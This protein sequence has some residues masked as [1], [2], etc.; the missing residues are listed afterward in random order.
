[1]CGYLRLLL[2]LIGI[3]L[4]GAAGAIAEEVEF[5][6]LDGK[7]RLPAELRL[8]QSDPPFRAIVF[9]HGCSGLKRNGAI[10][11][12]YSAWGKLLND[13]GFAVLMVDSAAPRGFGTTCGAG[14]ARKRMYFNRPLDAYGA[15]RYL[16][17]RPDVRA[18]GIGLAG[19]SQG[20]GIT[21]LTVVSESIGRPDPRPE[22]D[23]KA[24]VAFYPSACSTRAQSRPYTSVEPGQWSTSIPLLV[25]HG[26]KDNWTKVRP[27]QEFVHAAQRRRQP[28]TI[29]VYPDAAHSFDAP[30]LPLQRRSTP[31]LAD[32][33]RP[34][35]GTNEPARNDARRRV[36]AHFEAHIPAN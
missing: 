11:A 10:S 27:C 9:L 23:F 34:L 3:E 33:T 1:M 31:V 24:A 7:T 2:A 26:A 21:L 25:L 29:Q 17:S 5:D 15:L 35:I 32:G 6:S 28:V 12:T 30:S 18:D 16:Q 8:P 36:P 22:H 4:L 13:A 19:W 20:G 14:D